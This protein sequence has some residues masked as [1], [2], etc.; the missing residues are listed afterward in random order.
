MWLEFWS[1]NTV[2]LVEKICNNSRD[3]EFF[4]GDYFF[5][6]HPVE[7]VSGTSS[8]GTADYVCVVSIC[9]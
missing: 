9:V 6:A 4:L 2:N 7:V 3:M 8:R 1:V 5:M